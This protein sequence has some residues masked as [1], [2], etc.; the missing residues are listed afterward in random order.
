MKDPAK[1]SQSVRT[2]NRAW[3][4]VCVGTW[5]VV[6]LVLTYEMLPRL[7]GVWSKTPWGREQP[8]QGDAES[9]LEAGSVMARR[10]LFHPAPRLKLDPR[11]MDRPR[12]LLWIRDRV[13]GGLETRN[14]WPNA[15][16]LQALIESG[17]T[18]DSDIERYWD[19]LIDADGNWL[20]PP[21]LL[22]HCL[23]G[24]PLL[25]WHERTGEARYRVAAQ[26]LVEWL[27]NSHVRSSSGT[28]P[29]R[30]E[31]PDVLLV[32]TLGMICPL[33][34]R[35]GLDY[36]HPQASALA[37]RQLLEFLDNAMDARSGLPFHAYRVDL[38]SEREAFGLAG[39]GRGTGWLSLG[40]AGTLAWLP[41]DDADRNRLEEALRY[42]MQSVR[43]YQREDGLWGWAANIPGAQA[44]TSATGM[45]AW[46][47]VMGI[48]GG[49]LSDQACGDSLRRA[50]KGILHHTSKAGEVGQSMADAAGVGQYPW[51]FAHTSWAQGFALLAANG[52]V[53]P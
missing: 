41:E 15:V 5:L 48:E 13:A 40:L 22:S 20:K 27:L 45:L 21:E 47:M 43:K 51:L 49:I 42:L 16:L 7:G 28:L 26:R 38:G 1:P 52:L 39:W 31:E 17:H 46:S 4:I 11:R 50:M 24:M 33:L 53:E 19:E 2:S 34:A 44:D 3:K 29:Y 32:D 37:K 23:V 30:P 10:D 18:I 36:D 14:S 25:E 12:T 8:W 6:F 9:F 35:Y